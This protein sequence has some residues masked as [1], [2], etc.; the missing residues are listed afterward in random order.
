[1]REKGSGTRKALEYALSEQGLSVSDL[2]IRAFIENNRTIVECVRKNMGLTFISKHAVLKDLEEGTLIKIPV[3]GMHI[4][5]D[6]YFVYNSTTA[7]SPL[8]EAFKNFVTNGKGTS[9]S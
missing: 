2:N 3:R 9:V 5:R 6:F 8:A 4:Y 7:L 1:L